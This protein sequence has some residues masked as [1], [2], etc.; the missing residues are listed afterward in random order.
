MTDEP[1]NPADVA[2]ELAEQSLGKLTPE[3]WAYFKALADYMDQ[4]VCGHCHIELHYANARPDDTLTCPHCG[5]A[6]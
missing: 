3:Q 2:R 5:E 4:V 1:R 6:L